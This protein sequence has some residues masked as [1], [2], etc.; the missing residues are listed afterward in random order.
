MKGQSQLFSSKEQAYKTPSFLYDRLNNE[1][2]FTLD[3]AASGDNNL[4]DNYFTKETN[5]LTQSWRDQVVFCNPPYND[6]DSFI[7]KAFQEYQDNYVT[8]VLLIPSRTEKRIW[9]DVIAPNATQ[10]RFIKGRLKFSGSKDAAPFPSAIIIF[11][12]RI[13][14]ERVIW[15]DYR[16]V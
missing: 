12:N 3:A 8:S 7:K 10:I 2:R 4:C 6:Q 5:G 1:F 16:E 13:Y 9:Y 11:S 14:D 15:V